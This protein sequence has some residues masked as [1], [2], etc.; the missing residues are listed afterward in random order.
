MLMFL[1]SNLVCLHLFQ[2]T[3][4]DVRTS[5]RLVTV[6][7]MMEAQTS[8]AICRVV[9]LRQTVQEQF[10]PV[11]ALFIGHIILMSVKVRVKGNLD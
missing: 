3:L 9:Y 7:A 11:C 2:P 6:G 5:T 8:G 1:G 4:V 10:S